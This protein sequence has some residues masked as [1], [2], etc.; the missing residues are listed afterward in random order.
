MVIS[1]SGKALRVVL[2]QFG[3]K[4]VWVPK[5]LV[6]LD[7]EVMACLEEGEL[8]VDPQAWWLQAMGISDLKSME[9]VLKAAGI[10]PPAPWLERGTDSCV[11]FRDICTASR[12]TFGLL[13]WC[14]WTDRFTQPVKPKDLN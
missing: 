1:D 5:S 12:S 6:H 8:V 14:F 10:C 3:Q 4:V 11:P 2:R 7:S 13:I 9:P